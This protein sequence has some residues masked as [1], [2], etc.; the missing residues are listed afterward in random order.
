MSFAFPRE[1]QRRRIRIECSSCFREWTDEHCCDVP[2]AINF[3]RYSDTAL[4]RLAADLAM[5]L[6]ER[7][8][9]RQ[10]D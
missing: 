9:A 5:I 1:G 10:E 3:S 6:A 4:E 7:R 8:R 2:P